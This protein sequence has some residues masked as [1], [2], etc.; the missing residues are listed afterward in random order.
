VTALRRR[1]FVRIEGTQALGL[2]RG[3]SLPG[4]EIEA[5]NLS[6]A[7]AERVRPNEML[8]VA[9]ADEDGNFAGKLPLRPHDLVRIRARAPNGVVGK[10]KTFRARGLGGKP[11]PIQVALFR[12][13]LR[14][15]ANGTIKIFNINPN[16]PIAEPG[17]ILW[18]TNTRT[19]DRVRF[20]MNVVGSL[21]GR[22]RIPGRAEDVLRIETSTANGSGSLRT[23]GMLLTPL[24]T[25][26]RGRAELVQPGGHHQ[27]IGFIPTLRRFRVPLFPRR[28]RPY[29]VYQSEL[30]NCYIASAVAAV[31]HVRP[32]C[33]ERAIV[34]LDAA[35]YQVRFKFGVDART[36][37]YTSR[38]V[39]VTSDL[40]V[41]P[42][43]SLLYGSPAGLRNPPPSLWWP[44]LEKAF[45]RLKGSYKH[46]GRG[47][48][49]HRVLEVLLGRR[50]R[51]FFS[52]Q[53]PPS[54]LWRELTRALNERRPVVV[55]TFPVSSARKYRNTGL[56]PD[57]AYTVLSCRE[58]R[59]VLKVGL[60]NPWGE[61]VRR[62]GTV[63]RNGFFEIDFARFAE[64]IEVISTVR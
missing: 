9:R 50:P 4:A 43:G 48:C 42:S 39:I 35:T 61:D 28:P 32:S 64:L 12:L 58:V 16:R 51:H 8:V 60:R 54:D 5:V 11:R 30:G 24:A 33:L 63:R 18:V 1:P 36:G 31:A 53:L 23:A 13:G 20:V 62:P 47:G 55:G 7:P 22:T 10:S 2:I 52:D 25:K 46:I 29:D 34:R 41:R 59:G 3:R 49:S 45:A 26:R 21:Q 40:Y 14:D 44:V 6:A 15:L 57:H 17:A 27:K 56:Y 38:N 37:R 19:G